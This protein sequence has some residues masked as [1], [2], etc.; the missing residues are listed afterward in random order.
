MG[1]R[2]IADIIAEDEATAKP[3]LSRKKSKK[4]KSEKSKKSAAVDATETNGHAPAV[5]QSDNEAQS[6]AE[7]K[8][9]KKAKK[10]AK[11]AK[12]PAKSTR[13]VPVRRPWTRTKM[14]SRLRKKL[15]ARQR[16]RS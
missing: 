5:E 3:E 14:L 12:R 10:E 2:P 1:K 16:R 15:P 11:E 13:K 7:R 6:K 4:D 9:A 8:A